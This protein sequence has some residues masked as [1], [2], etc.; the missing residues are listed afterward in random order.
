VGLAHTDSTMTLANAHQVSRQKPSFCIANHLK[1]KL[2]IYLKPLFYLSLPLPSHLCY[3]AV[4]LS[5]MVMHCYNSSTS[6]ESKTFTKKKPRSSE[7]MET[8]ASIYKKKHFVVLQCWWDTKRVLPKVYKLQSNNPCNKYKAK[9]RKDNGQLE[10]KFIL[11]K[12]IS[13][14][15]HASGKLN[16]DYIASFAKFNNVLLGRYQ[17]GWKQVLYKHFPEPVNPEVIK[18]AQ[19][20]ALTKNFLRAI[21]L[22]LI[23]TL[24]KKNSKDCQFNYLAPSGDH[25]I[26]K[27]LLASPLDHLHCFEEMLCI[28][29]LLPKGNH[30]PPN[31]ALQVEWFYM[32]FRCSDHM[33]YVHSGHKLNDETLQIL[34]KYFK[35][36][37]LNHLSNDLIQRK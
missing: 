33:E 19:D 18:P 4:S 16:L 28:T 11:N 30:P 24:N 31:A 6:K 1:L 20:C 26:L 8:M 36:I 2:I 29:K 25:G 23:R 22:F 3:C 7:M 35:S 21:K 27:E 13:E 14:F 32:S 12:T 34:A 15:I 17:T 10:I 9:I 5:C 37:F